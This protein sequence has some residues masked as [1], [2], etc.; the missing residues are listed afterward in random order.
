LG[1]RSLREGI[2]LDLE[3]DGRSVVLK[4][5]DENDEDENSAR[6]YQPQIRLFSSGDV[7]PFVVHFRRAFEN[8]SVQIEFDAEGMVEVTKDLE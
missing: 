3:I 4:Q 7:S 8:K 2:L 1:Q 5:D 6:D